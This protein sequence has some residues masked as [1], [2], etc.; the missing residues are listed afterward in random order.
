MCTL[1][2]TG[3]AMSQISSTS[4]ATCEY[5]KAG[6]RSGVPARRLLDMAIDIF[7]VSALCTVETQ[8]RIVSTCFDPEPF[9]FGH[10]R[11]RNFVRL[12]VDEIDH[13][14]GG[15][16]AEELA[17]AA[18]ERCVVSS[19]LRELVEIQLGDSSIQVSNSMSDVALR[20]WDAGVAL[21]DSLYAEGNYIRDACSG[22]CVV[23]IGS[24]VGLSGRALQDAGAKLAFL[25]D[26]PDPMIMNNLRH[27][28][29]RNCNPALVEGRP[30]DVTVPKCLQ[31]ACTSWGVNVVLGA[32][33]CFCPELTV[34][35]VRAFAKILYE[36]GSRGFLFTTVRQESTHRVLQDVLSECSDQLSVSDIS[37]RVLGS[38]SG[39][40]RFPFV[41]WDYSNIEVLEMTPTIT[42]L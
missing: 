17:E 8:A 34:S 7:G 21:F 40:G 19:P 38:K 25:T 16:L 10:A 15:V 1:A 24:G 27:N 22:K 26:I 42:R 13:S 29:A 37:D 2:S 5:L 23:E 35:M 4:V 41:F 9:K 3:C 11:E 33:L 36:T 14:H 6:F 39:T 31:T 12:L 20:L 30:L 18:V 32:D 28:I